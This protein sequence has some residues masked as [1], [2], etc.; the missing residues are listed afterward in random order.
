M[1]EYE[2]ED[3]DG[4]LFWFNGELIPIVNINHDAS[5]RNLFDIS[6]RL[7]GELQR[8]NDHIAINNLLHGLGLRMYTVLPDRVLTRGPHKG[9]NGYGG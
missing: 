9:T 1:F 6:A 2:R 7:G 3:D 5:L 4:E 8:R